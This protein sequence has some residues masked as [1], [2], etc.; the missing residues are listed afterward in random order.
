ME[1]NLFV[2]ILVLKIMIMKKNS[3]LISNIFDFIYKCLLHLIYVE[4]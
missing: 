4:N 2:E 3:Q 1:K